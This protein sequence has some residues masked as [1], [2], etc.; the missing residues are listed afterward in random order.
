MESIQ[1]RKPLDL[2]LPIF[3]V[4]RPFALQFILVDS[5]VPHS[6]TLQ[7]KSDMF[8]QSFNVPF[9]NPP[10]VNVQSPSTDVL[11]CK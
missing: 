5:T 10:F 6:L 7:L 9:D 8:S 1:V 11:R 2:S 4:Y 3:F